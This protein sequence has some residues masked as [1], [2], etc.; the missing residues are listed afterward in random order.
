MLQICCTV[1]L[2][3]KSAIVQIPSLV[4]VWNLE[5]VHIQVLLSFVSLTIVPNYGVSIKNNPEPSSSF[6]ETLLNQQENDIEDSIFV[7]WCLFFNK[8]HLKKASL[9]SDSCNPK[10]CFSSSLDI[11]ILILMQFVT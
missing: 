8:L 4:I 1:H 10:T 11:E 6:S 3:V 7:S 9:C 2:R 5:W